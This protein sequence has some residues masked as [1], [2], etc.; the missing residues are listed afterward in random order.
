MAPPLTEQNVARRPHPG[1]E[2]PTVYADTSPSDAATIA[3][4]KGKGLVATITP[5][6]VVA[7]IVGLVTAFW[8]R[9]PDPVSENTGNEAR[10]CNESVIQLRA[11]FTQFRAEM[12]LHNQIEDS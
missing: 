12:A 11:D 10:R 1:A 4:I 9:R 8:A 2:P 6:F 5:H 3:A 7:V